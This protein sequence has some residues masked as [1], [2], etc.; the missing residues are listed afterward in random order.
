MTLA[1][2]WHYLPSGEDDPQPALGASTFL[3][4]APTR[5]LESPQRLCRPYF[6]GRPDPAGVADQ[7]SDWH[8]RGCRVQVANEPNHP[9]EE[10]TGG[11]AAFGSW[12]SDV[13]LLAPGVRLYYPGMS[14]GFPDWRDWYTDP[15]CQGAVADAYG[16]CVHAYGT[17]D[18]MR[19]V[20]AWIADTYP[21]KPL[22]LGEVNFGAGQEVDRDRWA[23]EQLRPFLD[24]CAAVPTIEAVCYFAYTWP[25]PD[26]PTPTPV[27][28]KGTRIET[29]L[30]EWTP[31]INGGSVSDIVLSVPE[32]HSHAVEGNWGAGQPFGPPV[33]VTVHST[34][35]GSSTIE[36][37]YT[38]T[39]NWF[40]NPSSGVSAQRVVGGG[41][42][43]EVNTSA[44]DREVAYHG[45]DPDNH[46]R[47][48]IELAHGFGG[49]WDSVAYP[50]FQYEAAGELIAR[51][52]IADGDAWPIRLLS[53]EELAGN[54]LA[55]GIALHKD[56]PNGVKDG[57][58]DPSPP[59]DPPRLIAAAQAWYD[60]LTGGAT[61]PPAPDLAALAD[62]VWGLGDQL[63][64]V[65]AQYDAAGYPHRAEYVRSQGNAIK[66]WVNTASKL[67]R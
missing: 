8:A 59:F 56:T 35:G 51:W 16:L 38:A 20:T 42:F 26:M 63:M 58:R 32:R 54:P 46:R 5:G 52:C 29:V 36:N 21:H 12:F 64:R 41:A 30:R 2:G 66:E 15:S 9:I 34:G 28:G 49:A 17:L 62:Q 55:A 40:Q 10:F 23:D 4:T 65:G 19:E 60:H 27:D 22:W 37:E 14:P 1:V 53:R 11:P 31:P 13:V 33:G 25:T 47:H 57:K 44:H 7:A 48:S 18:Q 67:Q 6:K 3:D 43:S 61:L 39:I 50:D 24:W 45:R